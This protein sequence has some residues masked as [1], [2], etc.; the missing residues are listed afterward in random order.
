M[1]AWISISVFFR[2][3]NAPTAATTAMDDRRVTARKPGLQGLSTNCS[4]L[5]PEFGALLVHSWAILGCV[6]MLE[7][8]RSDDKN[9]CMGI[10]RQITAFG[11]AQVPKRKSTVKNRAGQTVVSVRSGHV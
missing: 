2:M 10:E 9:I 5:A 4:P 1:A 3:W 7:L 11:V 6:G 8:G